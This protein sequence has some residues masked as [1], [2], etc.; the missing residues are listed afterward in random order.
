MKPSFKFR[1]AD[2]IAGTFVILAGILFVVAVVLAGRSQGWFEG[3][4]RLK[5]IFDTTEGSYGLKEGAAVQVRNTVAGRVGKIQPSDEGIM[6]TTLII[7]ERFRPFITKTSV[8]KVKKTF[9]LAGDAYIE[10]E[11]GKGGKVI[12]DGDTISCVKDE[13]LMET[14]QKMIAEFQASLQPML[15]DVQKIVDNVSDI[16]SS[17]D[18]GEGVAGA[19]ISDE[20]MRDDLTQIVSHLNKIS[21]DA[22]ASVAQVSNLLSNNLEQVNGIISD[23]AVMSGQTRQLMT[24]QVPRIIEGVPEMQEE[25]LST[26]R[27]SR[28]LIVGIQHNW[29]FRKYIKQDSN[30]VPLIPVVFGAVNDKK[31]QR[32]LEKGL[33]AARQ[34]DDAKAIAHNAYNLA[35]VHLAEGDLAGADRLNTEARIAC[36]T[37][38]VS[39]ASTYLLEAE[40]A[41]LSRDFKT[42]ASLVRQAQSMLGK[43][44]AETRVES[45]IILATIYLDAGDVDGAAAEL[46]RAEAGNKKHNLPQYDAAIAGLHAGLCMHQGHQQEAADWFAKQADSLRE[47]EDYGSMATALRQAGDV[48]SNIDMSASAAEYYYRAAVAIDAAGDSQRAQEILGLAETAAKSAGDALM[49][50]R[51]HQMQQKK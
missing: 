35:V 18:K 16:L 37:G 29:L 51:I 8:A 1:H 6:G 39:P 41:R 24:N 7:K 43:K 12:E 34:S 26:I 19:V 48:Y 42:A 33:G 44:D 45:R 32:R 36:R 47:V 50:K 49:L 20:D 9:G 38:K 14:A 27:E 5:V 15:D 25:V 46:K 40:L 13:E 10:I 17:I 28:K 2:E 21:A 23:V 11:R 3:S 4:F 31:L 30:V 22:D